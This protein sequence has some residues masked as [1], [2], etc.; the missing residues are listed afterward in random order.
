MRIGW[1]PP[2]FLDR[3]AY[4][5]CCRCCLVYILLLQMEEVASMEPG[6]PIIVRAEGGSRSNAGHLERRKYLPNAGA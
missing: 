6:M 5:G 2:L 1:V 3:T 4:E